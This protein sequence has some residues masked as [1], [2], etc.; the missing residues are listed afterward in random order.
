MPWGKRVYCCPHCPYQT[1]PFYNNTF[2]Q[3]WM[4]NALLKHKKKHHTE[5]GREAIEQRKIQRRNEKQNKHQKLLREQAR[6]KA[7]R[8]L[9][10]EREIARL[11][12]EREL[13][14]EAMLLI[15]LADNETNQT[16]VATLTDDVLQCV[17]KRLS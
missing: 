17:F 6:L 13:A 4:Y 1:P 10:T 5:Q 14:R 2:Q 8:Q 9:Q 12:A 11:E 16:P 15:C 3:E 7:E